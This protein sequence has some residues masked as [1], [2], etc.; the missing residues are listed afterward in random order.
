MDEAAKFLINPSV[1]GHSAD[2]KKAFLRKKGLSEAEI[3]AAFGKV[4]V[5]GVSM[6]S[7]DQAASLW[8][9]YLMAL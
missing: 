7:L 9:L 8:S 5:P 2:K 6:R 1:I 3:D 4:E